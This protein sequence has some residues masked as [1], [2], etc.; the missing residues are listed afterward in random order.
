MLEDRMV[1]L[2]HG[3]I[4]AWGMPGMSMI[5]VVAEQVD[6][7]KLEVGKTMHVALKKP[8]SGMFQ[9]VGVKP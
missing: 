4:D 7:T 8:V 6:M 5:F 9:V 3:D 2:T 1:R